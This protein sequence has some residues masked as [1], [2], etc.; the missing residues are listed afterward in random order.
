MVGGEA[1]EA[2]EAKRRA[3][4]VDSERRRAHEDGGPPPALSAAAAAV[5]NDINLDATTMVAMTRF[6][7]TY[8]T[9]GVSHPRAASNI[10]FFL[11]PPLRPTS[12]RSPS[13][14]AGS[15]VG[16]SHRVGDEGEIPSTEGMERGF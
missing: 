1:T 5:P 14:T 6:T 3:E 15:C 7:S 4:A 11:L 2:G 13:P 16:G 9:A 10:S 8:S 12:A